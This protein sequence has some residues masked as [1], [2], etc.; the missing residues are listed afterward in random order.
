MYG[1]FEQ[2]SQVPHNI[3]HFSYVIFLAL[4]RQLFA[5]KWFILFSQLLMKSEVANVVSNEASNRA[6]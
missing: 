5:N 1:R 3:K 6:F 2:E 4:D